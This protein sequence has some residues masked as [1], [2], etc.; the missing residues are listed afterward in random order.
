MHDMTADAFIQCRVASE[1]KERFSR[2]AQF[3]GISE[4]AHLKRFIEATVVATDG[5]I[6]ERSAPEV[7]GCK[8]GRVSVRLQAD[9]L[10]MLR[11]RAAGRNLPATT[12]VS[13]LIRSH[14]RHVAPMPM[15]ELTAL[16][17]SIAEVGAIG[18]NINQIARAMNRGE[19][20]SAL[21][22]AEIQ[23][24]IRALTAHKDRMKAVIAANLA[25]WKDG[26][27]KTPG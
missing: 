19:T 1:T 18:R 8:G 25:S 6:K 10:T 3:Q 12:Y 5:V 26:F 22:R 24:L 7:S 20:A 27:E 14:L 4:S 17:Q 9:D 2:A 11:Q 23:A 13:F 15:A 21:T 16:K